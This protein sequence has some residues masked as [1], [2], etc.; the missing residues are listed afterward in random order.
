MELYDGTCPE[1]GWRYRLS[2]HSAVSVHPED[3]HA[4][5]EEVDRLRARA[6]KAEANYA[7][8]VER[9]ANQRLD[10]YRELGVRAA[11]A[12]NE[13]DRLRAQLRETAQVLIAEVGASGP[14]DAEE[15]ARKAVKRMTLLRTL[16]DERA[17]EAGLY[18]RRMEQ[19]QQSRDQL[20][21]RLAAI[22]KTNVDRWQDGYAAAERQIASW[23]DQPCGMSGHDDRWCPACAFRADIA[24]AIR[25]GKHRPMNQE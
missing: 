24:N 12:E 9:A 20:Q 1:C 2:T 4:L 17:S 25:D 21:E 3:L 11:A 14:M 15:A 7:F 6:E 22:E 10:G 5:I 18:A 16:A 13:A 23:L 8:M 19:A